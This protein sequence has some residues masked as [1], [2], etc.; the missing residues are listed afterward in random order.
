MKRNFVISIMLMLTIIL[1]G[2]IISS[3]PKE[4][5]VI[6]SP[7][8]TKTFTIKVFPSPQNYIWS[9]DGIVDAGATQSSYKY[10]LDEVLPSQHTIRVI[11]IYALGANT[12]TWNIQYEGTN[13]PPTADAG[14]DQNVYAG[15]I[16]TL[17]GSG[18]ADPDDNIVSYLWE[19][20]DGPAVV[21][22]DPDIASPKFLANVPL[23]SSMTFSLTVTDAAGKFASDACVVTINNE[24]WR[25]F[26]QDNK[27]TGRSPYIGAQTNNLKWSFMTTGKYV[28]SSPVI[29]TNGMVYV[30]EWGDNEEGTYNFPSKI[31]ALDSDTGSEIWSFLT[32]NW[33][34]G[35]PAIGADGTVYVASDDTNLYALDG[36]TG[37]LKWL[38]AAGDS[39][40][41]SPTIGADGTV[42][43][44]SWDGYVYA[45]DPAT[46]N[47]K[48]SYDTMSLVICSPAIGADGTVYVG[49]M[50]GN[51]TAIDATGGYKWGYVMGLPGSDQVW[52]SPSI[53]ADGT[54]YIGGWNSGKLYALDGA[55]GAWKWDY[56]TGSGIWSCPAIGAD[57]TVYVTSYYNGKLTALDGATG[58]FKWDFSA[59]GRYMV[60]SPAIGADGTIYVG[61]MVN[62]PGTPS[63]VYALDGATGAVKWQYLVGDRVESSPAIGADGTVYIGSKDGNVYAFGN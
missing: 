1:S 60:S 39:I 9:V 22:T 17:D 37:D 32:Q 14:V 46:G 59:A 34:W 6:L 3:S 38:F 56:N 16:V 58:A 49:D 8:Q 19:Q 28:Y 45:I 50:S 61:E 36:M 30:G 20:T 24:T 43:F 25:M 27:H 41:G 33:I 57:G 47:P 55:T 31:Y 54:V 5:P 13:K 42:Y 21:L 2:C 15:D 7:G 18:S 26:M 35:A 23:G 52:G 48:W 53:G 12:H 63:N 10:M 51:V 40:W 11:A 44:D 62:P 4:N 29:G